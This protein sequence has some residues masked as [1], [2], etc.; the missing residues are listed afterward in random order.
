MIDEANGCFWSKK[1]TTRYV[2]ST[3]EIAKVA[4]FLFLHWD[5]YNFIIIIY[6]GIIGNF[7]H[8]LSDNSFIKIGVLMLF[9]ALQI[10]HCSSYVNQL[11]YLYKRENLALLVGFFSSWNMCL[12]YV[13]CNEVTVQIF[14]DYKRIEE[15]THR[16][17]PIFLMREI[18]VL[19]STLVVG[20]KSRNDLYECLDLMLPILRSFR[21]Q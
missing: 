15:H 4:Y 10:L 1:I 9:C 2:G 5:N 17:Y 18:T 11:L 8:H 7:P 6:F 16:V 21:K 20:A 14:L 12:T 13:T 3:W 19:M